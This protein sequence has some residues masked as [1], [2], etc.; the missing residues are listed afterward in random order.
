M[1]LAIGDVMDVTITKYRAIG[2][3]LGQRIPAQPAHRAIR[4]VDTVLLIPVYEKCL[5]K[6]CL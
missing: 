5:P 2:L 3:S 1:V 6:N 4:K